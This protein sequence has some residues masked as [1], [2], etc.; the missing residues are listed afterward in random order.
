MI[1]RAYNDST[2]G[3]TTSCRPLTAKARKRGTVAP[4]MGFG[5]EARASCGAITA[6]TRPAIGQPIA[7]YRTTLAIQRPVIAGG[8]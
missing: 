2:A 8:E 6:S 4:A 1:Y 7:R 3:S 5:I